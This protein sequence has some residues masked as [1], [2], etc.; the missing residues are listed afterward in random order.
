MGS[1]CLQA[2][3]SVRRT[4]ATIPHP[5]MAEPTGAKS[6]ICQTKHTRASPYR[7]KNQQDQKQLMT[8]DAGLK[9]K[10]ICV[11]IYYNV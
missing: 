7:R 4:S 11:L 8:I 1:I 10:N 3:H 6:K 9:I 2:S 5:G